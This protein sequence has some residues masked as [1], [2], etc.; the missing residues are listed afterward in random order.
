[1]GLCLI[2]TRC[3]AKCLTCTYVADGGVLASKAH[4]WRR[5]EVMANCIADS[6]ASQNLK[7]Y[8]THRSYF[9]PK[10]N[11]LSAYSR[12]LHILNG[13]RIRY[14][15][16]CR[17]SARFDVSRDTYV[18]TQDPKFLGSLGDT[19]SEHTSSPVGQPPGPQTRSLSQQRSDNWGISDFQSVQRSQESA[20]YHQ[21]C[22]PSD[23]V[24]P[25][26]K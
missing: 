16:S 17:R 8:E 26:P 1:V 14:S 5:L 9:Y 19:L 20:L 10:F 23:R 22:F 6:H 12:P 21:L 2:W 18:I 25:Y 11:M 15:D 3:F 13:T 4:S 7:T 24:Q